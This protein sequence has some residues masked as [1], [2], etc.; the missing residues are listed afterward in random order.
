MK[1]SESFQIQ[2]KTLLSEKLST[3]ETLF[4][5]VNIHLKVARI[6]SV[7]LKRH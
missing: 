1:V 7:G 3:H 6:Y 4:P 5:V 2:R